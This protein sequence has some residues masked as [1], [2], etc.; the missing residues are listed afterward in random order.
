[1]TLQ[2]KRAAP[3]EDDSFDDDFTFKRSRNSDIKS[4]SKNYVKQYIPSPQTM[5]QVTGFLQTVYSHNDK[6]LRKVTQDTMDYR[7]TTHSP[8]SKLG[9]KQ[10]ERRQDS[11]DTKP[12][13]IMFDDDDFNHRESLWNPGRRSSFMYRA[14]QQSSFTRTSVALPHPHLEPKSY[15]K[16][17][18]ADMPDPMRMR[19]LLTWCGHKLITPKE[20]T[21]AE[22]KKSPAESIAAELQEKILN[23]LQEGKINTSW[24]TRAPASNSTD[25]SNRQPNSKNIRNT[26]LIEKYERTTRILINTIHF[27]GHSIRME[28]EDKAWRNVAM[29]LNNFH[30][31]VLDSCPPL[32]KAGEDNGVGNDLPTRFQQY[33]L[34]GISSEQQQFLNKYCTPS[35]ID[36]IDNQ[37]TRVVESLQTKVDVLQETLTTK[38][39]DQRKAEQF[40][41][42]VLEKMVD[43]L[44]KREGIK[45]DLSDRSCCL[46]PDTVELLRVLANDFID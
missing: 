3:A 14:K 37:I 41:K 15:Y 30:A 35:S 21:E 8:S 4:D 20:S 6:S 34:E 43:V 31:S 33:Y 12:L 19:Q 40:G 13:A 25:S 2:Y 10:M 32:P 45:A 46:M 1:M 11:K 29:K 5:E 9:R 17:I 42:R 16:H 23:Q 18:P 27:I 22:G 7:A 44:D 28:K 36:D 26:K 24:Y 39:H 38:L